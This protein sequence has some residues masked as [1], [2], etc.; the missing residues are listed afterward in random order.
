MSTLRATKVAPAPRASASGLN[1]MSIEP[2]GVDLVRLPGSLVGEYW[3][4]VRP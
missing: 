3:P 4:L 1:G 2:K